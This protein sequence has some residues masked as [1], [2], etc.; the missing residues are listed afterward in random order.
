[1]D[2]KYVCYLFTV[3]DREKSLINFVKNYQKFR[4]GKKHKLIICFKQIKLTQIINYRKI[5]KKIKYIEFIDPGTKNDWDFGS[6]KRVSKTFFDKDILFLNSHSYPVCNDW[7]KKLFKFKKK[8]TVIAP[9]ASY[10]SM[11]DSIKLKYKFHKFIRFIWRKIIFKKNFDNFPN[12]HIRTS[13]FLINSKI[14]YNFIKNKELNNKFD[15][16]KIESGKKGLTKFLKRKNFNI[17]VVNFDGVKFQEQD[18]YKSETYNYFKKNK[19]IISDK[20]TRNYS[21]LNNLEKIKMRKKTW[22]KN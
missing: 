14:F 18:W 11:N 4:S 22:G 12:P 15:T 3:Y 9:M 2:A 17:F 10:E 13:S 1:M 19:A 16:L 7:L 8:N 20:Y 21:N 6:Y 5:L